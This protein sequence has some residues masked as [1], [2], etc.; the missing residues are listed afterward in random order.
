V[1]ALTQPSVITWFFFALNLINLGYM[2]K[3]TR[4]SREL[5]IQYNIS[6]TIRFFSLIV[7]IAN[8]LIL[9]SGHRIDNENS[10]IMVS[11]KRWLQIIGLKAN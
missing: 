11:L 2:I 3:G 10:K 1:Q 6:S 9:A 5:K 8:I 7:I 4:V